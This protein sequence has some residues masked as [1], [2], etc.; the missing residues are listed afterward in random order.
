MTSTL[1]VG[2]VHLAGSA[3]YQNE[4]NQ[5]LLEMLSLDG[6]LSSAA[7]QL[8]TATIHTQIRTISAHY[9]LA[10]G[11]LDVHDAQASVLGGGL[12][13]SLK[14]HDVAS[15]QESQ[16]HAVMHNVGLGRH[17]ESRESPVDAA[18]SADRDRERHH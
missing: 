13:G 8:H 2:I 7:L 5:P 14:V 16:L 6:N 1:P 10:K 17:P 3:R 9:T 11:D 18:T 4:Q 15:A 12:T